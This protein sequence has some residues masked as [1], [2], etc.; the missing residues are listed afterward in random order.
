MALILRDEF[1]EECRS[2]GRIIEEKSKSNTPLTNDELNDVFEPVVQWVEEK[3]KIRVRR[4]LEEQEA[5]NRDTQFQEE[6]ESMKRKRVADIS[7]CVLLSVNGG[8][9]ERVDAD[10]CK[11]LKTGLVYDIIYNPPEDVIGSDDEDLS[12][13][14][15]WEKYLPRIELSIDKKYANMIGE[16]DRAIL[17][18]LKE[19]EDIKT[20]EDIRDVMKQIKKSGILGSDYRLKSYIELVDII[21]DKQSIE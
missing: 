18:F 7:E 6:V 16:S 14:D 15:S 5:E 10:F 19:Q 11:K 20:L 17:S 1:L 2:A 21:I 12:D 9:P 4:E 13:E 8:E 3:T